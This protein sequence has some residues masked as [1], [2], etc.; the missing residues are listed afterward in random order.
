MT[1][2]VQVLFIIICILLILIVLLQ[3]GRGGGLG[4]AF[5]D[6]AGSAFGTRTGDVLTWITVVLTGIFLLTAIG[7]GPLL[8]PDLGKLDPPAFEPESWPESKRHEDSIKVGINM[9]RSEGATVRYVLVHRNEP[10]EELTKNSPVYDKHKKEVR[11]GS[12]LKARA[13]RRGVTPSDVVE[14]TYHKPGPEPEPK[15]DMS[16]EK[17]DSTEDSNEAGSKS[18]DS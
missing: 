2:L 5:G 1:T 17:K 12:T 8:K 4:A 9:D 13:Y 11:D 16:E 6:G 18:G 10:D 7:L 15:S 14:C 3:K